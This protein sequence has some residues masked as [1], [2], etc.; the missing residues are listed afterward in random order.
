[1]D[2]HIFAKINGLYRHKTP[3]HL[4]KSREE[5]EDR[6]RQLASDL[7]YLF[8]NKNKQMKML[9][10]ISAI[11]AL[12]SMHKSQNGCGPAKLKYS[13]SWQVPGLGCKSCMLDNSTPLQTQDL[14]LGTCLSGELGTLPC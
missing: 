14:G 8:L 6:R 7:S 4:L 9:K 5:E 11:A 2:A 1:M 12:T 3:S 13:T 10:I